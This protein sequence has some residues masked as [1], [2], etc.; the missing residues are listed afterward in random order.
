VVR[1]RLT[2]IGIG[3]PLGSASLSWDY[4]GS[5]GGCL[6]LSGGKLP[7]VWQL[8]DPITLGVHPSSPSPP[9]IQAPSGDIV[10]ERVPAYVS[11][12]VDNELR[13]RLAVSAFVLLVGDSSAGK[14]RTAYEAISV[15]P[16]HVLIAPHNRDAV[17]VAIEKAESTRRCVLWLDDLE[18]YLGTGG[19]TRSD[20][21]RMLAGKRSHRV[22]V[23]TLRA[24]E[25]I[26]LTS[27][28][29][30]EDAK[31]Q[32]RRDAREVLEQ[33]YRLPIARML[34]RKEE[35][36]AKAQ[37]WDP[38][39]AGALAQSDVYGLAEY[40]AAGPELLR[41]WE[42]AW[43]PNTDPRAPSHPRGAALIAAA[44]DMRRGGYASPLPRGVLEEVHDY[45][46][47]KRGR[48]RLRPEPMAE[49]WT[50]AT[51]PRR[52][53]TALLEVVDDG[54]VQ[55][56]DYL[57]DSI[58]RNS[59]PGDHAP[60]NVLEAAVAVSAPID[61]DNIAGTAYYHS[62]Y[63]LAEAASLRAYRARVRELGPEHPDTLASQAFHA[64]VLRELGRASEA[65]A[66]HQAIADIAGRVLGPDHPLSLQSR[67]GRAFAL[68]RLGRHAEAEEEFCT[69]RDTGARVLGK[70]HSVTMTSRHLRAIALA[71][72]GRLTEAESEN[73]S[74]LDAWTR[75]LGPDHPSTLLSR[76]NLASVLYD[77]GRFEEAAREARAV[78]EI[79]TRTLG[80]E[81]IDTLYSRAFHADMLRELGR[82]AETETEYQVI[83]DLAERVL[84]PESPRALRARTGRAFALIRL[85]RYVEAE[86]EL[87][88]A[89]DA[90]SRT[91]GPNH[92]VTMTSRHLRAIALAGLGRLTEAESENRSVLD[93]WTRELG[94]DHP[95]TLLSRGNLASVLYDAGRFEE[96]AR[97]ARAVLEIR[98]RTLGLEHPD[99]AHVG[100]LLVNIENDMSHSDKK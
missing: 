98:T 15:L 10:L 12:D 59:P 88:A 77:A 64:N 49:A 58:Q 99:T 2:G 3:T 83:I 76:G 4:G 95:S 73:R 7:K 47:S 16:D 44:V 82:P 70:G 36:R 65:Y 72:L 89:H 19:L 37:A 23:A 42:N 85:G 35:D 21:A 41:D 31:W 51:M 52:A 39:V 32:F 27:E 6:T 11:R 68:I 33:A 53:T 93:D 46:L 9:G 38:R 18:N 90:S 28:T 94:P 97:E 14:S 60:D 48:S 1:K 84:G 96:A 92:D 67:N 34:S 71:R 25:E 80:P 75:E 22:I 45:Y 78:L 57:L 13:Q 100:S 20:I 79:R 17:A 63:N 50:W 43:S 62:R 30:G 61:A 55:V 26:R 81:H 74:V 29:A 69:I 66:E 54:H 40:L 8:A 87:R 86:E 91:L 24:A 5:G 56:F